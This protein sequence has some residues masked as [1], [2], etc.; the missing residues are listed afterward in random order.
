MERRITTTEDGSH[1]LYVP[2]LE[3]HFHSTHGAIR[4]SEHVFIQ[5]GL[6][7]CPLQTITILEVG[8][9]TGL[10]ALLTL[11]NKDD[12]TIHY[13]SIEKFPLE[14]EEYLQLNYPRLINNNLHEAFEN[15]HQCAW[16]QPIEIAPGFFLTKLNADLLEI[17]FDQ[18]PAFNLIYFDAFAP[19]K[20]PEMWQENIFEKIALHTATQGLFVTYC[21]KGEVR[22][23]LARCGFTMSRLP[24]PPGKKEMLFGQKT[25]S[26]NSVSKNPLSS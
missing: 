11:A 21:A 4:E 15:M 3:E 13:I 8:F 24:G 7:K 19:N 25:T 10:N 12:K 26:A 22:R 14:K 18:F 2:E 23:S 1:T 20:Q 6:L 9:G 16:E 5:Q 17:S